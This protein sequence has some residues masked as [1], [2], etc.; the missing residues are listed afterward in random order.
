[1]RAN[2]VNDFWEYDGAQRLYSHGLY[3]NAPHAASTAAWLYT[4]NPAGQIASVA[5]DNDAYAWTGAYTV[6]RAYTTN[7]LNQYSAAGTATFTYDANGNLTSDGTNTFTYDVENRLVGRSAP[8]G[9]VTLSYDPLG[10][11]YEV[12]GGSGATRFLYDGDAL[13]A[14]YDA[15]G[16]MT[17]RYVH[18]VGADLPLLS[19]AGSG[20]GQLTYL[21][22]D[23]QGSIVA[24]SDAAGAGTVNSYD[25][26]G[27]PAATNTGRFQYTGQIWLPELGMYHYKARIYSPTLG[28]FLQTDPIGYDDQFNLYAYVGNDPVNMADPSG[29]HTR[30][31]GSLLPQDSASCSGQTLV[32]NMGGQERQSNG[33]RTYAPA[34]SDISGGGGGELGNPIETALNDA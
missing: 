17:R 9:N 28:R 8:T 10:R 29:E 12:T 34:G 25:E 32:A 2:G 24:V 26:Y 19:Y 22:A 21:H 15:A 3:F 16:A 33:P 1:V 18:N 27:I 6:N 11:L 23:H 4:H 13:V 30:G 5:R 31:C 20:I 14:E 7:G